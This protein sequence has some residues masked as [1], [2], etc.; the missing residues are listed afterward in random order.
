MPTAET[1]LEVAERHVREGQ[2]RLY[3]LEA[4]LLE[5]GARSRP[6]ALLMEVIGTMRDSVRLAQEHAERLEQKAIR[7]QT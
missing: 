3:R 6:T 4:L 5:W 2:V 1:D 7:R